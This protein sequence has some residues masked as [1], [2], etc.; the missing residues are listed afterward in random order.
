MSD[1]AD[2]VDRTTAAA[3]YNNTAVRSI[4]GGMT[5]AVIRGKE[6]K[7]GSNDINPNRPTLI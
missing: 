2:E 4:Q 1:E 6:V 7:I 3:W 5:K